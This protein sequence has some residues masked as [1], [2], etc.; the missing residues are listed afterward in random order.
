MDYPH[1]TV[2]ELHG[3]LPMG[4]VVARTPVHAFQ[5]LPPELRLRQRPELRQQRRDLDLDGQ[6]AFEIT[7]VL[8]ADEADALVRWSEQLG[9]R[10]EAP[11]ITTP[12]GMRMNKTVHWVADH[13]LLGPIYERIA[14]LLPA[15]IGGA[16]LHPALSHRINMYRYDAGDV[17][18][19]HLDGD[20]PGYSLG[21]DGSRMEAWDG[22][23]SRL[24]MLLY[25]NDAGD[26]V[27]GGSTRLYGRGGSVVDVPPRKGSALFFRHGFSLDSVSHAG[28]RVGAGT[29]KYVARINVMYAQ[30]APLRRPAG[31]A[32]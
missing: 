7:N 2:A 5:H 29:P 12:P 13:A 9:Y 8:T 15:E 27:K 17:F 30:G 32:D 22:L 19:R 23:R 10:A 20:W 25:L 14:A 16:A 31:V 28:S 1:H 24:T 3:S 11:G 6:L 21:P 26:G 4:G 18:N